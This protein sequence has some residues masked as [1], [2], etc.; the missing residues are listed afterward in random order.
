[1]DLR[2]PLARIRLVTGLVLFSYVTLHL[3][4]HTLGTI[5]LEAME[6]GRRVMLVLWRNPVGTLAL[7]GSFIG[8]VLCSLFRVYERR[9]FRMQ[10]WEMVQLGL[11]L[12]IPLVLLKHMAYTRSAAQHGLADTYLRELDM[13]WPETAG[14]MTAMLVAV[15]IHG[16]I[17]VHFWLKF[18]VWYRRLAYPLYTLALLL[19]VLALMG[20][21]Q[22]GR[23]VAQ[24]R[25]QG[26]VIEEPTPELAAKLDTLTEK[27]SQALLALIGVVLVGRGLRQ[28]WERRRGVVKLTYP[29]GKVISAPLGVTLLEASRRAN[30][31]H[32]SLCGGR[33]RCST[34][35]T[36]IGAGLATLPP[37]SEREARVLRQIAAPENVRLGCQVRPT[38]DLVVTPL[39]AP[40]LSARDTWIRS[41]QAGAEREIA[42][43]FADIR[44][45][46]RFSERRL[47][48]DVVFVLNQYFRAMGEAIE[49]AGG[50]VDK[51]IGDGVMALFG[52]EAGRELGCRQAL[53]AAKAMADALELLNRELAPELAE[54][55]RIG[56]GIHTG[57]AIVGELGY[58]PAT[59]LTAIG[60]AVNMASRLEAKSAELGV[61]LVLSAAVEES[62]GVD[63]SAFA[64]KEV[65]VRG[66]DET[67]TVRVV[68]SARDLPVKAPESA[69]V[70]L[71]IAAAGGLNAG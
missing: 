38:A 18:R 20:V 59:A 10:A 22:Q 58:G 49:S 51:F 45:F 5:S 31:P 67:V 54:P 63:L 61:Q 56:I 3:L 62:A 36:R 42:I 46:T 66:R 32:V 44:D 1:M 64:R 29:G 43:L 4:N 53:S 39:V 34:C 48:Y 8:H 69:Q 19:P 71:R 68:P 50:R 12:F 35:R 60:D 57:S 70:G 27:V 21:I 13:F 25:A 52:M 23:H 7:Y 37:P 24:L 2:Q 47:P 26:A 17:G 33:G 55:L 15:W 28:L 11:A 6:S 16:C 30:I 65:P 40:G 14:F 9:T 41:Q